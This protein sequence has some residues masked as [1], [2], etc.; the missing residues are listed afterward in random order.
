MARGIGGK[1]S[2]RDECDEYAAPAAP[3]IPQRLPFGTIAVCLNASADV[4]VSLLSA[5]GWGPTRASGSG[6]AAS[7]GVPIGLGAYVA[8]SDE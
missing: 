3:A 7:P 8:V 1:P 4:V 5:R 2:P 6:G